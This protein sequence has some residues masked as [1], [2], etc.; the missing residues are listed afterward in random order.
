M[1]VKLLTE[2]GFDL[3]GSGLKVGHTYKA[4]CYKEGRH[5]FG[6]LIQIVGFLFRIGDECEIVKDYKKKRRYKNK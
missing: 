5:C 1:K 6:A 3:R 4:S 2:G